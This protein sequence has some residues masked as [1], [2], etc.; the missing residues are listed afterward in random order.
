M[1]H[2]IYYRFIHSHCYCCCV[3]I[4]FSHSTQ[5]WKNIKMNGLFFFSVC[6]LMLADG[7][8]LF[9]SPFCRLNRM[10]KRNSLKF[11][12]LEKPCRMSYS[13]IY[14]IHF[15]RCRGSSSSILVKKMVRHSQKNFHWR[16]AKKYIYFH[17]NTIS[18]C[19]WIVII[20]TLLLCYYGYFIP[21][22]TLPPASPPP[23]K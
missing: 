21:T 7:F 22:A 8:P 16:K 4:I 2:Y 15:V 3:S 1:L 13:I 5:S 11:I 14:I 17:T 6:L 20:I 19:E 9:L 10:N 18:S 12:A 23:K